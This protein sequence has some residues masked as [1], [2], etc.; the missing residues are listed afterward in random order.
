MTAPE[1]D[2]DAFQEFIRGIAGMDIAD[3]IV[4]ATTDDA[5]MTELNAVDLVADQVAAF[6]RTKGFS[7]S[8]D[9]LTAFVEDRIRRKIPADERA[10]RNR[11]LAARA[12]G[13][14]VLPVPMDAETSATLHDVIHSPGYTLDRA[15]VLRGNV[16]ALR[17]VPSLPALLAMLEDTLQAALEIDDLEAAHE[18]LTFAQLKTRSAVAYD[19]LAEDDRVAHLVGAIIDDLGLARGHVLWEWPGF[20]I[21]F[22]IEAGGRGVYRAAN[23]GTLAAHRDTWYGSPQ[24]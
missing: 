15:S 24:H 22:P 6:A 17:G 7:F 16:I 18:D 12:A 3:F 4:A 14:A 11:L 2:G 21:L 19:R 5:L 1:P 23:S 8:A 13:E 9:E 10:F 20:R